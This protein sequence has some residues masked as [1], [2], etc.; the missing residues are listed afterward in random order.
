M[1]VERGLPPPEE[2]AVSVHLAACDDCRRAATIAFLSSR[3]AP[4]SLG[5][6]GE[7]QVLLAV[8]GALARPSSCLSENLLAAWL[9]DGLPIDERTRVTEHLA[10]CDDCRRAAAL[11]RMSN[12]EPVSA[13]SQIQER[14]ALDLVLKTAS[15]DAFFSFGR[16]AA[17]AI[18]VAIAATYLSTQWTAR[19]AA[20]ELTSVAGP[21]E[22]RLL[23]VGSGRPAAPSTPEEKPAPGKVSAADPTP[24]KE[25]EAKP[26]VPDPDLSSR[27]GPVGVHEWEG[28]A[29]APAAGRLEFVDPVKAERAT[30]V[31]LE[32]R[33]LV[34]LDGGSEAR[35]ATAPA[36][37][38]LVYEASAGRGFID[39]VG[40]Q[41]RWEI[42]KGARVMV[43]DR[44]RGRAAVVAEGEDLRVLILRGGTEVGADRFE[45][46]CSLLAEPEGGVQ[47]KPG[48][49]EIESLTERFDAVRPKSFLVFRGAAGTTSIKAPWKFTSPART[50]APLNSPP[51][52]LVPDGI[53][54]IHWVKV[55]LDEPVL[56]ASD[57]VLRVACSGTGTKI[58]LW[59][60]GWYREV[61]RKNDGAG[62]EEWALK[63]L[64]KEM[65]DLVAGEPLRKF[66]IGVV[67]EG[68]K[69][70]TLEVDAVEVRRNLE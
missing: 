57:M 37:S 41:Q 7:R 14:R 68:G 6:E 67:Q 33:A 40:S 21:S 42:R 70:R 38:A 49:D 64:R 23:R 52:K 36:D 51:E 17:A 25:P 1:W 10:A 5:S 11:A 24:D 15:R 29:P 69:A 54:P 46:G 8:Q 26:V 61:A 13:L 48:G 65:V 53:D 22:D 44:F 12:A 34:V 43:L 35:L 62:A 59:A 19:P 47:V 28:G 58:C 55:T 31:N 39:T 66:M 30:S 60:D 16:V 32:G 63:G 4:A 45:A 27:F 2:E 3:E 50:A 9:Q 18:L 20:P 56:Y